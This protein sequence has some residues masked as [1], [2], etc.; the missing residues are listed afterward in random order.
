[1][2][3]LTNDA[4]LGISVFQAISKGVDALH[5]KAIKQCNFHFKVTTR[6][7]Y[8]I[9]KETLQYFIADIIRTM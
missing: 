2:D 8:F 7:V 9:M 1:M 6:D 4:K 5:I 3:E